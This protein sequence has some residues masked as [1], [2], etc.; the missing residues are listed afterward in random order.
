[1]TR[2]TIAQYLDDSVRWTRIP[3][4]VAPPRRRPLRMWSTLAILAATGAL[5][6]AIFWPALRWPGYAV[7]IAAF[8]IA[9]FMPI[10]GPL[11][12]W[13]GTEPI[14]ERERANRARAFLIALSVISVVAVAGLWTIVALSI[15]GNWDV[16]LLRQT[17][18][19]LA[20]YIAALY[21]ALPTCIASWTEPRLRDDED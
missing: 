5:V 21:S 1:M 14:D 13:G 17:N 16:D 2:K 3:A 10:F 15:M 8:G 19:D 20:F 18:I 9:N 12:P 7:L 6:V 4:I 11:K